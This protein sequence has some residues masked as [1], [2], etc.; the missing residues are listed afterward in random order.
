MS[1]ILSALIS[2]SCPTQEQIKTHYVI[3]TV[4]LQVNICL[5]RSRYK[6]SYCKW[7]LSED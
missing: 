4:G 7:D 5:K 1:Y 2:A 6:D 3:Q